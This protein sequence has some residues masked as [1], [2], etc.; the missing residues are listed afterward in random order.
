[1]GKYVCYGNEEGL[2]CWGR[3]KAEAEVNTIEGPKAV[4]I[5]DERM[6][7]PYSAGERIKHHRGDTL[8]YRDRIDIEKDV[9]DRDMREFDMLTNEDLFLMALDAPE[10]GLA[11]VE[12]A[13]IRNMLKSG[14]HGIADVAAE[15]LKKR[16][17]MSE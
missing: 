17:G 5:L 3:I 8:L 12:H 15:L 2:F 6:S 1:M 13:G 10:V 9:F 11:K 14:K 4:F 16:I 7:G